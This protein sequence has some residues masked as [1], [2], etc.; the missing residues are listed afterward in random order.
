MKI[1]YIEDNQIDIDLTL[2][3]IGKA[4][5]KIIMTVARSAEVAFNLLRSTE[6]NNYD[7]ILADMHLPD[8]DGLSL[9][10]MIRSEFSSMTVVLITGQGDEEVAV[11]ALKSGA[12]DYLSK[13]PG[14]LIRLPLVLENAVNRHH[15]DIERQTRI[16][17]V[18]YVE[19]NDVDIDLTQ[20]HLKRY[21]PQIQMDAIH[22]AEELLDMLN[23]SGTLNYDLI[24][25]DHR[26]RGLNALEL[27]KELRENRRLKIPI[28]LVTGH[29]DEEVAVQAMK[30]GA[31]EYIVKTA[32][33]L[34]HLPSIIEN[35]FNRDELEREKVAL[36]FSEERFRLLAENAQDV[37]YRLK[38]QPEMEF[39]YISPVIQ[40]FTGYTPAE[41]YANP[42]LLRTMVFEDDR[43][44]VDSVLQGRIAPTNPLT[45]RWVNKNGDILWVE[46]QNVLVY[47]AGKPIAIESITRD[48]TERVRSDERI[49]RQMQRLA[50]MLTIDNA[51]SASLDL[52]LTIGILLDNVIAHLRVDAACILLLNQNTKMLEYYAGRG[53]RTKGIEKT[54]LR[55]GEGYASKAIMERRIISGADLWM[56][57]DNDIFAHILNPEE[58][59]SYYAAPLFAK[60]IGK[61]VLEVYK[62]TPVETDQEWMEFLEALAGQTAIAIDNAELFASLQ[63]SNLDLTQ[64]YDSTLAGWVR[65]LDLRDE[66]TEGHAQRVAE[67]TLHLASS[68]GIRDGELE[69]IRRG[70]LLHDIGKVGVPDRILLKPGPLTEEEWVI[71]RRHPSYAFNMLSG[72]N[73]LK[74]ALDIPANH[75]EKWDGTGYPQGLKGNAIPLA[76]R[77][78]AVVDVWDALT[79]DRPYRS[80]WPREK[81][82][83]YIREQSGMHFDPEI[84][85]RFLNL[86]EFNV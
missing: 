45:M 32:D 41:L 34:Y 5:P 72:I 50:A 31:A 3:E 85:E 21:A 71:M 67:L 54:M 61:G 1:L 47:D 38:I 74:K 33:Y 81:A 11:A 77:I 73:Y 18:L 17:K 8:M 10:S 59:V 44:L 78:F 51:I 65:A 30:L 70:A 86:P 35:V 83:S 60:G 37:I 68:M 69:H 58:F 40:R 55:L 66:E 12:D 9:L 19:H 56:V 20:L 76:A 75:H 62:K 2:R 63:K 22:T 46:Q 48:I 13:R 79:S 16:I 36:R 64:A 7:G 53:F 15:A 29:G 39:D 6:G 24:M 14:Y 42:D 49:Q 57:E 43:K 4:A 52:R 28:I 25:L 82:I 27:L 26:L 23:R 84:V 80:A